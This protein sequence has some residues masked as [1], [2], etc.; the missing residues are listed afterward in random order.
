MVLLVTS[1]VS[2]YSEH[3]MDGYNNKKFLILML[4]FFGFIRILSLRGDFLM[5][6]IGWDGLGISSLFLIIFYPNKITLFNSLIT[7]SFNR[8]GDVFLILFF[9]IVFLRFPT[10]YFI[11]ESFDRVRLFLLF[12]CLLTKRAQAPFSRWLPAA[13]SAPTPISAIV[14]S[15]TLVTAGILVFFKNYFFFQRWELILL[16][17]GLARIR[18][19]IGGLMG[20]VEKDLKKVVAFSTMRQISIVI[21][22]FSLGFFF[23]S[24]SH[25]FCH[26]LFKTLLFCGCGV[27]FTWLFRDQLSTSFKSTI[28]SPSV[29]FSINLRI[30]GIRG[31]IFSSSF[32]T[33]DS[34]LERL[35]GRNY[36]LIFS[37]LIMG[38]ALTLIYSGRII[39][40]IGSLSKESGRLSRLRPLDLKFIIFF[41]G[42][43]VLSLKLIK[44]L[45][46]RSTDTFLPSVLILTINLFFLFV[47]L[48]ISLSSLKS[49]LELRV[50][51]YNMKESFFSSFSGVFGSSSSRV[52]WMNEQYF[53]KPF[54]IIFSYENEKNFQ[55]L[56]FLAYVFFTWR[57]LFIFY[58][59]SLNWTWYWSYQS[60]RIILN[61]KI[62]NLTCSLHQRIL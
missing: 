62:E 55:R 10:F 21:L 38:R 17:V 49:L 9:C 20:R 53:F 23:L 59:I 3:Y 25:T 11:L 36:F 57:S 37:L 61:L 40:S 24:L 12:L 26:A 1:L 50:R 27:M 30:F 60:L 7:L 18:F 52:L 31:L 43:R 56:K 32:Y 6:I 41:G 35:L 39:S 13:M 8:L 16:L 42:S 54:N 4:L 44:S 47:I 14:H 28:V 33:K 46:L 29:I 45:V 15:S 19:I 5:L 22:F 58:S 34:I 51:V 2:L 48:K